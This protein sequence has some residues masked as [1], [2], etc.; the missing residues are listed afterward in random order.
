MLQQVDDFAIACDDE[1][2]ATICWNEMDQQLKEPP[3]REHN[4]LTWHN[5]IDVLQTRDFV[6]V[7]CETYLNKILQTKSFP[8]IP[9][10]HKLLPM[11]SQNSDIKELETTTGPKEKEDQI[12]LQTTNGFKYRTTTGELIFALVTCRADIAF[13]VMKLTQYNNDPAQCHFSA[14]QQ[15]YKYLQHTKSEGLYFWRP[16]LEK[17]CL[18]PLGVDLFPSFVF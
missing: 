11:S 8:L 12:L 7:Y 13:P 2:T 3:K 10:S 17:T 5:G 1:T 16:T 18:N 14:I 4:L 6:K 15:V 9:T